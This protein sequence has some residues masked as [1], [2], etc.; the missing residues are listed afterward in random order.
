MTP[1]PT[2]V[3]S[4]D[5]AEAHS[6]PTQVPRQVP[7]AA[8]VKV[9]AARPR[10]VARVGRGLSLRHGL[11]L[12]LAGTLMIVGGIFAH[13]RPMQRAIVIPIPAVQGVVVT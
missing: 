12:T 10:L 11:M 3:P 2:L 6:E 5:A 9:R 7:D 8:F 4:T 13:K 1:S